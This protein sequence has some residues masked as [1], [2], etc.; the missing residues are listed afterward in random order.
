VL[1]TLVVLQMC[2][3]CCVADAG[4][5]ANVSHVLCC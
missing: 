4:G 5:V 1:L 3:T 2:H